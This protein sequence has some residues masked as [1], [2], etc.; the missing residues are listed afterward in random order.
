M[1]NRLT[2]T[3]TKKQEKEVMQGTWNRSEFATMLIR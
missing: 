2:L 1:S 3:T